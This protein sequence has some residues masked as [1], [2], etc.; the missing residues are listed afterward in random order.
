MNVLCQPSR[1]VGEASTT[2]DARRALR[3]FG[4]PVAP[5]TITQ[6]AALSHA[7]V[8]GQTVAEAEP[9]GKA[10]KEMRALWRIIE[11]DLTK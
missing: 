3:A 6:R 9:D 7:L 5:M 11:K 10:A 2:S 1:G 4:V 8:G